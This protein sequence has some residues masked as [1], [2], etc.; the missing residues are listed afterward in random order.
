M[1]AKKNNKIPKSVLASNIKEFVYHL[2]EQ[3]AH[4]FQKLEEPEL[5]PYHDGI[6]TLV[7]AVEVDLSTGFVFRDETLKPGYVAI[8][9]HEKTL[10]LI[11]GNRKL[12]VTLTNSVY[13]FLAEDV[14]DI[15][16]AIK[17]E[18]SDLELIVDISGVAN[19]IS[20]R[21]DLD[22]YYLLLQSFKDKGIKHKVVN[23]SDYKAI[24]IDN[25]FLV[26]HG[27]SDFSRFP[28]IYEYFL[29]YIK[30]KDAQPTKSVYLSRKKVP[31]PS[32]HIYPDPKT[33][34]LISVSPKRIDNEERLE[35]LFVS[36]GFEVVY[37]EDF[38]TFEE[39]LNFF[40]SVKTVASL[41]SSG[42]TNSIFMQ[43]GSTVVEVITPLTAR[44]INNGEAGYL[45]R[46]FHNYYKNMATTKRHLYVGLPNPYC[47]MEELDDFISSHESAVKVLKALA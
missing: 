42:L 4:I 3:I 18:Y 47:K 9:N 31:E 37:P 35:E 17:G 40:Y 33:N 24:Y 23:F 5:L 45:N 30:D 41:T 7:H 36:L 46:E 44:P 10:N 22:M 8:P 12:V 21:P 20:H 25:F 26:G 43:P 14:A 11:D 38:E 13:H 6:N 27:F 34:D 29:D 1:A 32:E 15:I 2:D 39:Q 28:D 19:F 16:K